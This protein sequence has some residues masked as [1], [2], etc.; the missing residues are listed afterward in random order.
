[1]STRVRSIRFLFSLNVYSLD[2]P[3]LTPGYSGM[4]GGISSGLTRFSLL[5]LGELRKF[6][7]PGPAGSLLQG[8]APPLLIRLPD[9]P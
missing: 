7:A 2:H 3:V 4:R 9:T 8:A 6:S 5:L 1:M